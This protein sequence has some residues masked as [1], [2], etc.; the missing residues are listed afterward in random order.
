[1]H[2]GLLFIACIIFT[3]TQ[4]K[5]VSWIVL[6]IGTPISR[7]SLILLHF[8]TKPFPLRYGRNNEKS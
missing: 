1:M 3:E 6:A 7:T 8:Y 2:S 5:Q 4:K